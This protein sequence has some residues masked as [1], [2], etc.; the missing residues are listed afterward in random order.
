MSLTTA[1]GCFRTRRGPQN[2]V[3]ILEHKRPWRYRQGRSGLKSV[4]LGLGHETVSLFRRGWCAFCAHVLVAAEGRV[5]KMAVQPNPS[6]GGRI[7]TARWQVISALACGPLAPIR[8]RSGWGARGVGRSNEHL[9]ST[10]SA[11]VPPRGGVRPTLSYPHGT[12]IGKWWSWCAP[13]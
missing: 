7:Q 11:F 3:T 9:T 2:V 12:I 1:S 5:G 8:D 4:P 10:L 6:A 13:A